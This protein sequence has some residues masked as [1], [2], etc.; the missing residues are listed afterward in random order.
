LTISGNPLP[1]TKGRETMAGLSTAANRFLNMAVAGDR[2]QPRGRYLKAT[3]VFAP[4]D[5]INEFTSPL[6]ALPD[7]AHQQVTCNYCLGQGP[8]PLPNVR[9]TLKLRSCTACHAVK[10]CSTACQKAD[11]SAVHAKECKAF[12][13]LRD[14]QGRDWLPTPVRALMQVLLR[15]RD[16]VIQA[17]FFKDGQADGLEGN[18]QKFRVVNGGKVWEDME[19]QSLAACATAGLGQRRDLVE[20]AREILCK[21][22]QPSSHLPSPRPNPHANS[23]VVNSRRARL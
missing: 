8:V 9:D 16:P 12:K 2:S 4:G 18:V 11:W 21:V 13:E 19:L 10:Y 23:F 22:S 15:A 17:A 20:K 3:Q 14:S 5:L 7:V 1:K 6:L